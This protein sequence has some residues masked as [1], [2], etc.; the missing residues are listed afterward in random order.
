MKSEKIEVH[1]SFTAGGEF[2]ELE[3]RLLDEFQRDFPLSPHPYAEIA[4]ALGASEAEV[5]AALARLARA[6]AIGRIGAVLRPGRLG[7]STLAAMAVPHE[8]L[9]EVAQIVSGYPGVN[10]NY[11]R[12]HAL[13]LWF[14]ATAPGAIELEALLDEIETRSGLRVHRLPMIEAYHIDLGFKL[15]WD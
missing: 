10:H 4:R 7:A 14:V 8:R 9:E 1:E 2:T 11:E 6:G 15:Q 3:R 13:N 12:E 5:L